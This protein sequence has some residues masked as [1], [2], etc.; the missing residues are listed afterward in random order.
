MP[1]KVQAERQ[2][3]HAVIRLRGAVALGDATQTLATEL[4]QAEKE[5]PGGTIVDLSEL[6]SL[7]STALG[8]LV[9]SLRRLRSASREMVLVNPN[10]H[11]S[12]LLHMTQL[13]S[14]FA[15]RRTVAEALELLNHGEGETDPGG[16]V[17]RA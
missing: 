3:G 2:G 10:E 6:R 15:V 11:V 12:T 14:V 13:D 7:D 16:P 17:K 8:L 5:P 1:M 4:G 9:G